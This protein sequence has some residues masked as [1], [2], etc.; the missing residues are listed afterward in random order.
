MRLIKFRAWNNYT[1]MMLYCDM[2][3]A[4]Y[5]SKFFIDYDW[6][7]QTYGLHFPLMQFTGILD[8]NGVEIYDGDVMQ[9]DIGIGYIV[10]AD[11]AFAIKSPGS[12]AVDWQHSSFFKKG[13]IIGN[14]YNNQDLIT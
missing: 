7:E 5:L 8:K 9:F 6:A 14:I 3:W 1:N 12:E 13:T 2:K 4:D 11:A 10:W